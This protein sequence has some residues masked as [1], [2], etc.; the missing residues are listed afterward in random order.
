MKISLSVIAGP[1]SGQTFSFDRHETFI[2][3]RSSKAD[4]RVDDD[5][6]ISRY[7]FMLEINPPV[8]ML[9]DMGSR[10]G[11]KL[12][13]Q[14]VGEVQVMSGD[15]ISAGTSQ[16]QLKIDP[17]TLLEVELIRCVGCGA[18]SHRDQTVIVAEDDFEDLQ[19]ICKTCE[20]RMKQFPNPPSGYLI[21]RRLGGGGMGDVYLAK[22]L[23]SMRLVAIKMMI[24]TAASSSRVR[25]YFK[26]E[27]T[28]MK[29]LRHPNIVEFYDVFETSHTFQIIMEYVAGQNGYEMISNIKRPLTVSEASHIGVQLLNALS[30]AHTKG[31][32]HRDIKPSNLLLSGA[33]ARPVL[34]LSD[35]GLAKNFRD[36]AGLSG[37]TMQGDIGGSIGFLSP[38]HIKNFT[39]V[40]EPAD[41]YST[42]ATLYFLLTGQYPFHDF[43]PNSVRSYAVILDHPPVPIRMR[44]PDIPETFERI[45]AKGLEK[46]PKDRWHSAREMALALEPFQD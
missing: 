15:I 9:K 45:L 21:E 24:P 37:L 39:K 34:K 16:F 1:Q 43:D 19:F 32:V 44:R 14:R 12:N 28:V 38:D 5:G 36:N 2:F 10:N 6:Y 25:E 4:C 40:K 11:T 31:F 46:N 41:I 20:R 3:G 30:H 18:T 33:Q 8:C 35:F 23:G 17:G 29:Q 27:M 42:A 22:D 7:H 26:R 13:G